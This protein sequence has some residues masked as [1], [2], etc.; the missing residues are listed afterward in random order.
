MKTIGI[1]TLLATLL[2]FG[3]VARAQLVEKKVMTLEAAN[4]IAAAAEAE[5][6]RRSPTVV[7]LVVDVAG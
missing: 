7:I 5:A 1:W 3:T 6:K 4:R 2:P